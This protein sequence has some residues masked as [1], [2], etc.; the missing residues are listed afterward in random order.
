MLSAVHRELL[1]PEGMARA[2]EAV[3]N[4]HSWFLHVSGLDQF[5]GLRRSGLM[6]AN[7]GKAVDTEAAQILGDSSGRIVC[8]RPIF[9]FDTTPRRDHDQLLLA[10]SN[11]D[12]PPRIG[13]DWSY[14]GCWG[15]VDILKGDTPASDS[16]TIFAEVVRRRGSIV[17][18][19]PVPPSALRVWAKGTPQIDPAKWPFLSNCEIADVQVLT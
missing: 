19:D 13:I 14:D 16:A 2:R 17:S 15:L 18:Y 10:I 4:R 7:P 1:M 8:L 9:T 12:I 5:E 11:T 3:I 6:P